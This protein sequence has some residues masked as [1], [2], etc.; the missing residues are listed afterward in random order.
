MSSIERLNEK[1][2]LFSM[3]VVSPLKSRKK[4]QQNARINQS[5]GVPVHRVP[6]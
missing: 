6:T 2:S 1:K 4:Q 5:I 3:R